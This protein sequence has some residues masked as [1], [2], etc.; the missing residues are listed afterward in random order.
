MG[1]I[2][3]KDIKILNSGGTALIA[4]AKSC[5]I[6]RHADAIETASASDATSKHYIPGRKEWSIDLQYFVSTDGVTLEERTMYNIQ[7][8]IGSGVTWVGQALC[9]DCQIDATVG[10]LSQGSIKLLGSG[11]LAPPTT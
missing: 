9:T 4:C 1:I 6:R 2:H 7:V 3:G 8:T 10:N 11:P 5:A